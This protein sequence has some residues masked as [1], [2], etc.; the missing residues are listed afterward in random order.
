MLIQCHF[1]G[2]SFLENSGKIDLISHIQSTGFFFIYNKAKRPSVNRSC[3]VTFLLALDLNS[4]MRRT[5]LKISFK[6][7]ASAELHNSN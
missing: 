4:E 5:N 6:K 2:M 3:F 7:V 1:Y